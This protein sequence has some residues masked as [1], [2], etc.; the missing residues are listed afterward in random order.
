MERRI[1][2]SLSFV[3]RIY[4]KMIQRKL[5]YAHSLDRFTTLKTKNAKREIPIPQM[6]I[7]ELLKHLEHQQILKD[8]FGEEYQDRDFVICTKQGE[9]QDSKTHYV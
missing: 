3:T 5:S 8:R 7:D 1:S 6:L 4:P 2:F 9:V